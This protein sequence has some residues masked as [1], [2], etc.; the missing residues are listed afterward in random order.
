MAL[1]ALK[2][3]E[4]SLAPVPLPSVSVGTTGSV[5]DNF[6]RSVSGFEQS[7][8]SRVAD[9]IKRR[10]ECAKELTDIIDKHPSDETREQATR[11]AGQ[12]IELLGGIIA[13]QQA[14]LEAGRKVMDGKIAN[15]AAVDPA[16]ARRL[17]KL[18]KR[19]LKAQTSFI[20]EIVASYYFFMALRSDFD[21]DA[22][23]GPSFRNADELAAYLRE[24]IDA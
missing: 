12:L 21:K 22:R 8:A 7:V 13:K 4:D 3:F 10:P 20:D 6:A 9:L 18:Q 24:Q 2:L 19:I 5:I 16:G 17:R 15:S 11:A 14:D 23:G 1:A